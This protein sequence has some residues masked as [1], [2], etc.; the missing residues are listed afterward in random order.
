MSLGYEFLGGLLNSASE[1]FNSEIQMIG[2]NM[3]GLIAAAMSVPVADP[4]RRRR[5]PP[6]RIWTTCFS[7]VDSGGGAVL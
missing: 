2:R 6:S 1:D 3:E 4:H 7:S 5:L